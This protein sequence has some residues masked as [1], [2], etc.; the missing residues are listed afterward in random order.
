MS[1]LSSIS[2]NLMSELTPK[3]DEDSTGN[4]NNIEGEKQ[5]SPKSKL[6]ARVKGTRNFPSQFSRAVYELF[7]SALKEGERSYPSSRQ[8]REIGF[9]NNC[10]TAPR[11]KF[12]QLL[13]RLSLGTV[14]GSL[15][16]SDKPT[17]EVLISKR[18]RKIIVTVEDAEMV[19]KRAHLTGSNRQGG[20]IDETKRKHKSYSKTVKAVS[21]K[22]S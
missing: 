13:P 18:T 7:M 3:Q 22:F 12:R 19:V 20:E 8:L 2:L 17:Q 1:F 11:Q 10:F 21:Y 14:D 9:A 5:T 6:A 15:V 4:L 16:F